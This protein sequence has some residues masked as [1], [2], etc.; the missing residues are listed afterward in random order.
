LEHAAYGVRHSEVSGE[1]LE[2]LLGFRQGTLVIT[3]VPL[4]EQR[5]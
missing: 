4:A 1:G 2:V 5:V 3:L